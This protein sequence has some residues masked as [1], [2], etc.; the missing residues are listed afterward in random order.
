MNIKVT[1][2]ISFRKIQ[3][4]YLHFN[5]LGQS[6]FLQHAQHLFKNPQQRTDSFELQSSVLL[7]RSPTA[8]ACS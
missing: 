4:T 5:P 8:S 6:A 1:W 2:D 3:I 7:Q